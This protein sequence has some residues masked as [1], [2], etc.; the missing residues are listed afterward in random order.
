MRSKNKKKIKLELSKFF[1]LI[2]AKNKNLI[3]F[4]TAYFFLN[5]YNFFTFSLSYYSLFNKKKQAAQSI[6]HRNIYNLTTIKFSY[7]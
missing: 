5:K 1:F 7:I 4:I 6:L 2:L 3:Y